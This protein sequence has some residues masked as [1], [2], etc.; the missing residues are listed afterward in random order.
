IR[1]DAPGSG[2]GEVRQRTHISRSA[3]R[4][5]FFLTESNISSGPIFTYDPNGEGQEKFNLNLSN[6]TNANI[7]DD[8]GV[9]TIK[10]DQFPSKGE[11][12]TFHSNALSSLNRD[13]SLIALESYPSDIVIRDKSLNPVKTLTGYEGGMVFDSKRDI[14]YAANVSTDRIVAFDTN[15]WNQLYTLNIGENINGDDSFGWNFGSGLMSVSDDGKYLF[16]STPSGV[17]MFD[18]PQLGSH[19]VT[20][21]SGQVVNAIDFGS[22]V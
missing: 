13:G 15:S 18:L 17:R 1:T 10:A 8:R 6:A 16:M 14:L 3:D 22:S 12:N 20:L 5:F 19:A 9:G 21:G 7:L 11:T 4:S 2:F